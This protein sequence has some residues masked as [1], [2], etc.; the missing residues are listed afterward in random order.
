MFRTLSQKIVKFGRLLEILRYQLNQFSLIDLE[1][2]STLY[3]EKFSELIKGSSVFLS[4]SINK[5]HEWG[6]GHLEFF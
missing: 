4:K 5:L 2:I 3:F 6:A 1:N